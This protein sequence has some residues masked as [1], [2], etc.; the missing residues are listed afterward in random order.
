M[1][2][3]LG[4]SFRPVPLDQAISLSTLLEPIQPDAQRTAAAVVDHLLTEST[5]PPVYFVLAHWWMNLFPPTAAGLASFWAARAFP[6]LLGVLSIPAMFGLGWLAFG[7]RL[8]GQLAAALMA[9]SP[10]SVF[11]AQEAR[12]YTLAI[13]LVI[14][15]LSC[16]AIALRYSLQRIPLP[17]WLSLVWVSVN[18]LG[19]AIHYFF[20]LTLCAEALAFG[21]VWLCSKPA[22]PSLKQGWRFATVILGTLAGGLVW[23]PLWQQS[24][25]SEVT[26][27][28]Y[29]SDRTLLTFLNPVFQLLAAWITMLSLLPVEA[30]ALPVIV[31]SGVVMLAFFVWTT[32][33]LLRGLRAQFSAEADNG[34]RLQ[35]FVGFVLAAVSL[36]FLLVYGL[37]TDLTRGARYNFVYFPAV[38]VLV[39]TSLAACWQVP[40]LSKGTAKLN[41]MQIHRMVTLKRLGKQAVVL[42]WLM[43]LASSLTVVGNL[44]YQKYYRPDLLLPI[45]EQ[46]SQ[47]PTLIATTHKTH[48]ETG[49]L[50]GLALEFSR[51][52]STTQPKFL[53]AHQ[54]QNPAASTAAL[55]QTL[56][57]LPRPLDLWLVNF[58]APVEL[59][60][61][62]CAADPQQKSQVNG[63]SYQL[64]RCQ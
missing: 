33:I 34:W 7:S 2:F 56:S 37:G 16:L 12:H 44:G 43:G 36:F 40:T 29:N 30:K 6:A 35:L 47:H 24:Y 9:V 55:Q 23:L 1:V 64:Y 49:E 60:P 18:S 39:A 5:H 22:V 11:L 14:A 15:S 10:Y 61:Q 62:N 45:M 32:P 42:V 21:I 53:L 50:M 13:L 51:T 52:G 63:Y 25:G 26:Q 17:I 46:A 54:E 48:V 4:K 41:R 28:I 27:W 58:Y 3:S 8:V 38:I 59:Q 57:S 19:I 20:T 31:L